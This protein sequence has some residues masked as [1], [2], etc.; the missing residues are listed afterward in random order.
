MLKDKDISLTIKNLLNIV[1]YWYC[2]KLNNLRSATA[3]DIMQFLPENKS[4]KFENIKKAYLFACSKAK[5]NDIVI[6]F[7]S[8]YT[9]SP[10]LQLIENKNIN[11]NN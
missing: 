8:F 3:D 1:N 11:S 9:V 7:G 10:I 4:K 5:K 6:V 2:A